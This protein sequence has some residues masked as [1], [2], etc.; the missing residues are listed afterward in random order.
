MC[1]T[2]LFENSITLTPKSE[3]DIIKKKKAL[4]TTNIYKLG[5]V[6]HNKI[7]IQIY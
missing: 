2:S 5:Y 4:K 1:S 3:K 7:A 6:I